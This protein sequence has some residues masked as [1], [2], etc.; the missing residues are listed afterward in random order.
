MLFTEEMSTN[1]AGDINKY[2]ITYLVLTYVMNGLHLTVSITGC[3]NAGSS[4]LLLGS[5]GAVG[6]LLL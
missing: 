6:A 5:T 1:L 3:P 2:E 4:V